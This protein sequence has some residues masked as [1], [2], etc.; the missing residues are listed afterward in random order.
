MT[1]HNYD[2]L[3]FGGRGIFIFIWC[4]HDCMRYIWCYT[5]LQL[6]DCRFLRN[7]QTCLSCDIGREYLYRYLGQ[8]YCSEIVIFLQ[9]FDEYQQIH[10]EDDEQKLFKARE[11]AAISLCQSSEFPINVSY[12][13]MEEFYARLKHCEE[14]YELDRDNF[15]IDTALFDNIS[16]EV[17]KL[18]LNNHWADFVSTVK[19][20]QRQQN[21][22]LSQ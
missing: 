2:Q 10:H 17:T 20:M 4:L 9:L 14:Q 5:V 7:Y 3:S 11:I 16:L 1:G 12:A 6:N 19:K 13:S 21:S 18:I 8:T 15:S 22:V